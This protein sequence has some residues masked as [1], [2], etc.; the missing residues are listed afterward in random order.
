MDTR[1]K[2][3]VVIANSQ[4]SILLLK[5]KVKKKNMP[6]WNIVKGS[7]GDNGDED[8][9]ETAKRECME[10][11]CLN[12]ELTNALGAYISKD[13]DKIRIQFNFS[14]TTDSEPKLPESEEQAER[15]ECI[16][17]IKWFTKDEILNM[18]PDEFMSN[19]IFELLKDYISGK[20]FPLEAYKQVSM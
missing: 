7:Y 10:E 3:G 20:K 12:V 4:G 5:E 18:N 1:A 17:E 6:L 2:V 8:I 9:F 14:A 19:R 13:G 11:V 15:D 16:S